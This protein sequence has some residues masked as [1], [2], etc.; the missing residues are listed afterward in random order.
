MKIVTFTVRCTALKDGMKLFSSFNSAPYARVVGNQLQMFSNHTE[1]VFNSI[2]VQEV[3]SYVSRVPEFVFPISNLLPLSKSPIHNF[4][5]VGI[6]INHSKT[7]VTLTYK[8][9]GNLSSQPELSYTKDDIFEFA[10]R[11]E[12]DEYAGHETPLFTDLEE[13]CSGLEIVED[14]I[15][16][17]SVVGERSEDVF[18][19]DKY[20]E[21]SIFSF[22]ISLE[23]VKDI[24]NKMDKSP[25]GV[26]T[27]R[28]V[29]CQN[30]WQPVFEYSKPLA[31]II[32]KCLVKGRGL[33][34]G[35]ASP[36]PFKLNI[37]IIHFIKLANLDIREPTNK[38]SKIFG[39]LFFFL[40]AD[41]EGVLSLCVKST[42]LTFRNYFL[43]VFPV[44]RCCE[45][46]R[47]PE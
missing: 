23:V 30:T 17:E 32:T 21:N 39:T 27:L 38:K 35:G 6:H 10:D 7:S 45:D 31:A 37:E 15:T 16:S 4:V 42:H 34:F 28:V 9:E 1:K 5:R 3:E 22:E 18:D 26:I 24:I 46:M 12:E 40:H 19:V 14:T 13:D 8:K 25:E 11:V 20:S 43:F 44:K 47:G 41:K 2:D 29:N 36:Q 33:S